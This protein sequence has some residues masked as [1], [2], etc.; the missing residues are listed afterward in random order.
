M[1][2]KN[3]RM[4]EIMTTNSMIASALAQLLIQKGKGLIPMEESS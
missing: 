4:E 1:T 3:V 2:G